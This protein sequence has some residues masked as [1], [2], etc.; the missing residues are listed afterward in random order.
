MPLLTTTALFSIGTAAVLTLAAPQ[1]QVAAAPSVAYQS[2]LGL[3]VTS[4]KQQLDIRWDHTCAAI[5]K[6]DK[7]LM[8][9]TEGEM[10]ELIPLDRRDLQD[11]SVAYSP[12]TN[13]VRI[14][15]EVSEKDGSSVSES[16]RAVAIP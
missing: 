14:R 4:R 2:P 16:A 10:T 3:K 11:G 1:R 13:D 9:V 15:L 12:M 5:T 7:A 6:A 8:K